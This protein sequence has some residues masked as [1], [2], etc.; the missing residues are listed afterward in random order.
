MYLQIYL[1]FHMDFVIYTATDGEG[2]IVVYQYQPE[3]GCGL[4]YCN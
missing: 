2:N 3:G 1:I 4:N